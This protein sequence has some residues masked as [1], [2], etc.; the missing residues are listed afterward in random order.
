MLVVLAIVLKEHQQK[1]T[2][3]FWLFT[4]IHIWVSEWPILPE[5]PQLQRKYSPEV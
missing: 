3:G 5:L 1:A 2:I 4:G